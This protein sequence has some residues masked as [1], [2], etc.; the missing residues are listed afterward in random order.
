VWRQA[1][2]VQSHTRN[3]RFE[4]DDCENLRCRTTGIALKEISPM[5]PQLLLLIA[6]S[7]SA[8][9]FVVRAAWRRPRLLFSMLLAAFGLSASAQNWSGNLASARATDWTNAGLPGGIPSRTTICYNVQAGDSLATVQTHINGCA[10]DT[11]VKFPAGT[12]T[13]SLYS[14]KGIVIRGAGPTQT[15]IN[16]SGGTIYFSVNGS[17]GMGSYPGNLGSTNWTGGL[18]K[19]STVLTL[20]STAGIQAGM[21]IVLDQHNAAWVFPDG[22]EG[23]CTSGNSCGRND[24][25]LQFNGAETR[26]QPEMV[27]VASVNSGTQITIA[28]P[29]VAF[30][31]DSGLAPQA[32]YWNKAGGGNI[33]HA[34]LEDI[35]I[36][37][38][39]TDFAVGMIFCDYCWVKNVQIKNIARAGVFFWWGY[40][41]ELRDS[42]ISSSNTAG[43][44][45]Q[46]GAEV[47][48]STFT[49]IENNIFFG[50]TSGIVPE[51]DY[52]LVIGYNYLLNTAADNQFAAIST[53]LSHNY[54]QLWEGNA[55]AFA[56]QDNSWG[57]GSQ[58][59]EFRNY[60]SGK[61]PNKT[62]YREAVKFGAHNRYGNVLANVIGT[63]GY[64]TIYQM[65]NANSPCGTDTYE[66]NLGFWND[67]DSTTSY[68]AT[69]ASSL[70]RWGNWDAV[71]N[72]VRYSA[73]ETASAEPTFPGLASPSTT[74][75]ASFYMSSKPAWFGN[76]PWPAVGPDVTCTTNCIANTANHAAKIPAQLCYENTAKSNG[77][78]TAFDANV[79]YASSATIPKPAKPTGLKGPVVPK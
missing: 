48:A 67:C 74:F 13:G 65:T 21:R 77:F 78:L 32:F 54:L 57:S 50:I 28:A 42:Y 2:V 68:D 24:S 35:T 73:S 62:N 47:I 64:H 10:Q 30:D 9:F 16:L 33:H 22:V 39:S 38:N 23:L 34:G 1:F 46:Y 20:A 8:I 79:C 6:F 55:A 72:A 71:T 49:K 76:V 12:W 5:N 60:F 29:G 75:P 58:N 26:A 51:T 18:T 45:T 70:M 61:D 66:F 59:T 17:S 69:V 14:N 19:G 31:H 40:R 25:P 52:G 7:L 4:A 56:N 11:V 41:D 27:E 15:T 37:A 63:L 3:E 44:P 36:N 43:A 53:H